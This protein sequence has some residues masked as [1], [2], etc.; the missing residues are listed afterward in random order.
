MTE[1]RQL[2]ERQRVAGNEAFKGGQWAEALRC[3]EI[4]IDSQRHNAAL[5]ANAA[6]AALKLGCY[7]QARG[8]RSPPAAHPPTLSPAAAS[9]SNCLPSTPPHSFHPLKPL[10]KLSP[11]TLPTKPSR[12]RSSTR[13]GCCTS[14][15]RCS[16]SRATRWW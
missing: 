9:P 7:V 6:M 5:H 10:L 8:L 11:K 14:R 13:T 2:A 12:R 15:S 4:G 3:Y 1:Q 16:R